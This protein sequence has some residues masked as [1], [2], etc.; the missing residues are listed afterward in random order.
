MQVNGYQ[1][2]EA[3]KRWNLRRDTLSK[4]IEGA[5][6]AFPGETK[7]PAVFGN[8]LDRLVEAEGAVATLE[9]LQQSYNQK[10]AVALDGKTGPLSLLVKQVRFCAAREQFW[11]GYLAKNPDEGYRGEHQLTREAN[12]V[13]AARVIPIE[14]AMANAERCGSLVARMRAAIAQANGSNVEV[15]DNYKSLIA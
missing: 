12:K 5:A 8:V 11:K 7:E 13:S 9:D 14:V 4:Q 10:V 6:W 15:D 2:R 3:L 1:V